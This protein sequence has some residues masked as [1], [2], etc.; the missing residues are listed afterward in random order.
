MA[1]ISRK[2]TNDVSSL[3]M[4]V[5]VTWKTAIYVRLSVED[6]GKD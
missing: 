5:V 6:N 4:N 1:R 2:K 3:N